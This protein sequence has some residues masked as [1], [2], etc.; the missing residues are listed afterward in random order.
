MHMPKQKRGLNTS[1]LI[2][3]LPILSFSSQLHIIIHQPDLL[4]GLESR[5]TNIRAPIAPE[6]IAESAVA[7]GP[8]F[9]LDGEVDFGEVLGLQFGQVRVCVGALGSVFGVEP[10]RQAA[11]AVL[12]GAAAL[13]VG[14]ACFGCESVS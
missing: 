14:F 4:A 10:L 13:G 11:A 7:A 8:D 9:T 12:A 5:Q 6:S 1:R 2:A 3:S